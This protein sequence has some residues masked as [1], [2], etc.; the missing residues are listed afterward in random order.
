MIN[1]M[2]MKW[3]VDSVA[4]ELENGGSLADLYADNLKKLNDCSIEEEEEWETL[5]E[6][7]CF[8]KANIVSVFMEQNGYRRNRDCNYEKK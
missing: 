3:R 6:I 2:R 4:K 5:I 1:F 7:D 8:L